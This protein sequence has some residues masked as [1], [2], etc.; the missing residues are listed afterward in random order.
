MSLKKYATSAERNAA[1]TVRRRERYAN[2]PTYWAS[3]YAA[4]RVWKAAHPD[5]VRDSEQRNEEKRHTQKRAKYRA[6]KAADPLHNRKRGLMSRYGL[7]V[8]EF[9]AIVE[10]QGGCAICGTMDD[11][12]P[13][14]DHET[15]R[16]RAI[17]CNSHN[18]GLGFFQ[19]NP[20]LLEIAAAYLMV[21]VV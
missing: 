16:I 20:T 10:W 7:S 19:D 9:N 8:E 1:R 21:T 17:L 5:R 11:L 18:R 4:T 3:V 13:D 14:H 12:V 15:G 6:D 2:D